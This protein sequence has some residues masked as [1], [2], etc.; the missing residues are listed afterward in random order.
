[1]T[2]HYFRTTLWSD[3]GADSPQESRKS[4]DG[5]DRLLHHLCPFGSHWSIGNGYMGFLEQDPDTLPS[6]TGSDVAYFQG[7]PDQGR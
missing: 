6:C 2:F 5:T 4:S 1:M 3:E 7:N